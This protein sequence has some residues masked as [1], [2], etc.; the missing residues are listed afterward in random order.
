MA[1]RVLDAVIDQEVETEEL[2]ERLSVRLSVPARALRKLGRTLARLVI[3]GE[4]SVQSAE[5]RFTQAYLLLA[6]VEHARDVEA[7]LGLIDRSLTAQT[8]A[9]SKLDGRLSKVPAVRKADIRDRIEER[10][11]ARR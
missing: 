8:E 10:R 11:N 6:L 3:A 9:I 7:A 4:I 2:L 1:Q 5:I